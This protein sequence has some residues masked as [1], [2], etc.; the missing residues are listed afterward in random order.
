MMKLKNVDVKFFWVNQFYIN[1]YII[2]VA[3][4][5]GDLNMRSY[6]F[7][8]KLKGKVGSE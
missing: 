7:V 4:L 1:I 8:E 2:I 3:Y 5:N 6:K